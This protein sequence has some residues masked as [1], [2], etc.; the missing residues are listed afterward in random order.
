MEDVNSVPKVGLIGENMENKMYDISIL[1]NTE[2]QNLPCQTH[3]LEGKIVL[4]FVCLCHYCK[5]R[6]ILY[7]SKL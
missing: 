4:N 2:I 7:K 5:I 1:Q 6:A 3:N